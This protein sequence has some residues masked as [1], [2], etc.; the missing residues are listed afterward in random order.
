MIIEINETKFDEVVQYCWEI[1]IDK[2]R[3]GFPR[4]ETYEHLCNRFL[5][6]L[7]HQDDKI[8]AYYEGSTLLGVLNLY[9]EEKEKYLQINYDWDL[10]Q[11]YI[12]GHLGG[13]VS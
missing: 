3:Y 12:E 6:T 9:V 2:T 8:L 11:K 7:Q 1:A 4:F 13:S 10:F 5:R